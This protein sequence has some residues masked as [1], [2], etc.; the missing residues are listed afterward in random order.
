MQKLTTDA[1]D[2]EVERLEPL[3][4]LRDSKTA[5]ELVARGATLTYAGYRDLSVR[6]S[7]HLISSPLPRPDSFMACVLGT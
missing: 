7:R 6:P 1:P 4:R 3:F 2:T 5:T